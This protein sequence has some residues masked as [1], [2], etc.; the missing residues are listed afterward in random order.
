VLIGIDCLN[1]DHGPV[2]RLDVGRMRWRPVQ[3]ADEMRRGFGSRI[4]SGRD[5]RS[6]RSGN[7]DGPEQRL[8]WYRTGLDERSSR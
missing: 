6:S 5:A 7:G 4:K 3:S 2:A 1:E 8:L